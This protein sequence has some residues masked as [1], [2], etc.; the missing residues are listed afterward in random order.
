MTLP[1]PIATWLRRLGIALLVVIGA[2]ITVAAVL[3]VA[4]R[5][6]VKP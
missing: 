1:Q 2:G 5:L 6:P 4:T 3:L